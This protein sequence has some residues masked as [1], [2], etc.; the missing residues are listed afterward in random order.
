MVSAPVLV[1]LLDRAFVAGSFAEAWRRRR[2]FYAALAATWIL[3]GGLLVSMG[4]N[5]GGS[6]GL[7]VDITW[8][9]YVLTQFPALVHYVRLSFW[10]TPL[11]FDYGTFWIGSLAD[12]WP[13]ACVVVALIAGTLFALVAEARGRVSRRVVFRDPRPDLARARDDAAHRRTPDVSGARA[14]GGAG[15]G[16]GLPPRAGAAASRRSWR[17]RPGWGCS[18]SSAMPTTAARLPSGRTRRR[19]GPPTP[20][21]T[22]ASARRSPTPAAWPRP[23]AEYE[24]ALR[25]RP[26]YLT[27]RNNL[28]TALIAVGRIGE[29]I[30]QPGGS[31]CARIRTTPRPT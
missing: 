11:V 5:R 31:R 25:L 23:S 28:G 17:W 29:A 6:A 2:G 26:N 10:P 7:G 18:P 1:L 4:G 30:Q 16:G 24:I 8:W 22:P 21:R 3:L 20:A 12:V 15:R 14:R 27:A 19:S 13:Q 9:D